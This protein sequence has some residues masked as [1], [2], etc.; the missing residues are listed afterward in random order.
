MNVTCVVTMITDCRCHMLCY[1][2]YTMHYK[3]RRDYESRTLCYYDYT[4]HYKYSTND[5][6]YTLCLEY[7]KTHYKYRIYLYH[8]VLPWLHA[9]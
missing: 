3:Y 5:K 4:I 8:T 2:S 6:F 9:R 7:Y 1:H